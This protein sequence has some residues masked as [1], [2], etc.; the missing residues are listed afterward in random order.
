MLYADELKS[1][2]D[3]FMLETI[4]RILSNTSISTGWKNIEVY[5]KT[6]IIQLGKALKIF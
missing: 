4:M 3:H 6:N 5:N 2:A 1:S